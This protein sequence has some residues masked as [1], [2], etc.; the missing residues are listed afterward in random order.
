MI[1][2][3]RNTEKKGKGVRYSEG[4]LPFRLVPWDSM[5]EAAK[6]YLLGCAKYAPR[7]WEKG[8]S[9]EQ[10]F[11]SLQR[12]AIFWFLGEDRDPETG[13]MHMAQVAWNALALLAFQLRGRKD[14]D[15]RPKISK[16]ELAQLR[17]A[18][19]IHVKKMRRKTSKK[20][21]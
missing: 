2:G 7:N 19:D 9:F 11:D 16:Q 15:D 4:K 1:K 17:E 8:L 21:R 14:L 10:T 12:H 5:V 18:V 6:V 13:L 20:R 3:A